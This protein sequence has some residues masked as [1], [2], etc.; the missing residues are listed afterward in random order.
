VIGTLTGDPEIK[1]L[2]SGLMVAT[3][4]IACNER[5]YNKETQ[6]YENG[7]AT[8]LRGTLW[9]EYAENVANSLRKGDKVIATGRLRMKQWEKDGQKR[10]SMELDIDEIGPTLRFVSVSSLSGGTASASPDEPAW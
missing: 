7:D 10:T 3:V 2:P 6:Q 1:A 8:Y 9:R 4:N 5:K